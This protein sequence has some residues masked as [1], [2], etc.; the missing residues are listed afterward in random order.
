MAQ[1]RKRQ[2]G[3]S[4]L[5]LIV[6]LLVIG[7]LAALSASSFRALWM[8]TQLETT[9]SKL[10]AH[11]QVARHLSVSYSQRIILAPKDGHSLNSGWRIGYDIDQDGIIDDA[12][13]F[14]EAEPLSSTVRVSATGSMNKAIGFNAQG[15]PTLPNGGF[16]A[17]TIRVCTEQSGTDIIM[18]RTGRLRSVPLTASACA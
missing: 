15:W 9:V 7:I 10:S 1:Q 16:Q 18:S 5:E 11:I 8:R 13:S 12:T 6:S 4:A 17:G 3:F 14:A 2:L